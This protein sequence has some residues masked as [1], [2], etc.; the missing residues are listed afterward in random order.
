L[1]GRLHKNLF[2]SL[3]LLAPANIATTVYNINT[4]NRM[5]IKAG[6]KITSCILTPGKIRYRDGLSPFLFDLLM[7]KII[8]DVTSL[9]SR[10]RINNTKPTT[11]QYSQKVRMTY[12]DSYL[13]STRSDHITHTAFLY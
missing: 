13:S 4:N 2:Y 6:E 7:D 8:E 10:Y 1:P 3:Y 9:K 12:R 5:Q 11:L